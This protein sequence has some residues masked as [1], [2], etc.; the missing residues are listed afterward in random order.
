MKKITI[1]VDGMHCASCSVLITKALLKNQ[2]I[3]NANVNY[4]TGKATIDFD[5]NILDEKKLI[6]II[7]SKGYKAYISQGFDPN[8]DKKRRSLEVKKLK[9]LFLISLIFSVPALFIGMF[10]VKHGFL[11]IGYEP[12]YA[13]YILWLLSTPVQFYVGYSFY[14]GT[15]SALKNKSASMDSLIAIGTSAAYFYSLYMLLFNGR[16]EYFEISAVLITL[17]ILGKLLEVIAK[18]KT[19]EAIQ[20]LMNISPKTANVI[21]NNK[22]INI[23]VDEVLLNDIILVKPGERIPVDGIVISGNSSVD[24]SMITG[25]SIPVEK[26][27]NSIVIGGTINKNGSFRFKATKVGKDTMLANIIKLIEDAQGRK[28]E[29][30]RFAD[31]V[32]SY[33]VPIVIVLSIITIG[34]K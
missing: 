8:E 34:T 9:N 13:D 33:F 10:L 4:S 16:G 18:G 15:W 23:L 25:E 26:I 24:E 14:Q 3:K 21:R 30:Q 28:A 19:S 6:E 20:K 27:K 2:G 22:E 11:F 29:I 7:N 1:N 17:I 12:P 32:S 5:D 31:V